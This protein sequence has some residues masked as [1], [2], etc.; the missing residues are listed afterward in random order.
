M[1]GR[2]E[3]KRKVVRTKMGNSGM[4]GNWEERKEGERKHGRSGGKGKRRA[5]KG[6]RG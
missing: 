2:K 3:G 4:E 1:E 6:I 5:K